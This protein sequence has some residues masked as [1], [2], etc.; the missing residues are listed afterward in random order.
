MINYLESMKMNDFIIG[1]LVLTD[2]SKWR[3]Q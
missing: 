3:K 2:I 1:I